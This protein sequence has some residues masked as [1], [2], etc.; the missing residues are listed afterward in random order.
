MFVTVHVHAY[1]QTRAGE[2]VK[3]PPLRRIFRGVVIVDGA[4]HASHFRHPDGPVL[5]IQNTWQISCRKRVLDGQQIS[6]RLQLT[7]PEHVY[8]YIGLRALPLSRK[9]RAC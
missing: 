1:K 7:D 4:I 6:T 5:V 2:R 9:L 8:T 3:E